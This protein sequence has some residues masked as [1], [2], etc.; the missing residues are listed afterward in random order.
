MVQAVPC[1]KVWVSLGNQGT[2]SPQFRCACSGRQEEKQL[3][4][5]AAGNAAHPHCP[6]HSRTEHH[7]LL[8]LPAGICVSSTR[9][10]RN[11]CASISSFLFGGDSTLSSSAGLVLPCSWLGF[12]SGLSLAQEFP[13]WIPPVPGLTKLSL[14]GLS[15]GSHPQSLQS[16]RQEGDI[17]WS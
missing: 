10:I 12:G 7:L 13:L 14:K 15:L 5:E 11:S 8:L 16:P 17:T 6:W 3:F 2:S 1:R 4:R 9:Q